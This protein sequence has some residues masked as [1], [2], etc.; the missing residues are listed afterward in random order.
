MPEALPAVFASLLQPTTIAP[1]ASNK[2]PP[3]VHGDQSGRRSEGVRSTSTHVRR[4]ER[5]RKPARDCLDR[6]ICTSQGLK[7]NGEA[8]VH[9]SPTRLSPHNARPLPCGTPTPNQG[10]SAALALTGLFYDQ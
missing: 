7:D 3:I 4:K 5:V 9:N 6:D 8:W 10:K 2:A 1:T